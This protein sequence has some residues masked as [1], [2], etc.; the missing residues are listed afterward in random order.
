MERR[1][2]KG[3]TAK[4]LVN[5]RSHELTDEIDLLDKE[6]DDDLSEEINEDYE[7]M[8]KKLSMDEWKSLFNSKD[9]LPED[10]DL[11]IITEII[12]KAREDNNI[13]LLSDDK[14]FTLPTY[15]EFLKENYSIEVLPLDD[16]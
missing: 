13:C 7:K 1:G 8:S 12:Q 16:L 6:I 5:K 2:I 3:K 4:K 9:P 14:H 15:R 10:N 11:C